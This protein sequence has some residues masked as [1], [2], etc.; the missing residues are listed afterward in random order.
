M[1]IHTLK[2]E[3]IAA[4]PPRKILVLDEPEAR[5]PDHGGE[6][7]LVRELS[8]ALHQVLV[9]A[10]VPGDDVAHRRDHLEGVEIV[11]RRQS[12]HRHL[13]ELQT[14]EPAAGPQHPPRLP[15]RRLHLDH[16][17]DAEGDGVAVE[18]VVLEGQRLGVALHP[19]DLRVREA[20]GGGPVLAHPE[21]ALVD[22][23]DD[24]LPAPAL[25]EP[26]GDVPGAARHVQQLHAAIWLNLLDKVILPQPVDTRGH[27]VVHHVVIVRHVVEH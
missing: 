19:A 2:A 15:Q 20:P 24:H 22:V 21:H 27:D 10:P 5:V 16:V 25:Q 23:A 17:A 11:Q 7:V 13:R 12:G 3:G 6:G 8:D 9:A 14:Q 18:T 1:T 26:E 4:M